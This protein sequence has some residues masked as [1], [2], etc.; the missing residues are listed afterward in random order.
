LGCLC[1]SPLSSFAFAFASPWFVLFEA[2]I[3]GSSWSRPL[4]ER[5]GSVGQGTSVCYGT[6]P[7]HVRLWS[8]WS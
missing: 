1:L 2:L 8:P 5:L 6:G 3:S 7:Y 4:P